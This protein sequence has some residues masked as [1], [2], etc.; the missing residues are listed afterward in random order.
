MSALLVL[1]GPI[2]RVRA[3]HWIE[4]AP[5]YTRV[6]F[7]G[8]KRSLDQNSAMWLWLTAISE[9]LDWHGQKYTADDWKD[10]MMHALR[11]ARWMP[12]EDGGMLP[13]GLRSS[14]LSKAQMS[15]LLELIMAFAARHSVTIPE[16]ADA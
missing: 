7:E 11:K 12:D 4:I 1:A 9:Q 6:T 2:I 16:L 13:I 14:K 5:A 3:Q 8:P 10:Y 15:D